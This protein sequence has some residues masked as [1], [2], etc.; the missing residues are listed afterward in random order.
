MDR[1]RPDITLGGLVLNIREDGSELDIDGAFDKY[2]SG[3][4]AFDVTYRTR[5]NDPYTQV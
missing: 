1:I 5:A 3:V 2:A 4:I